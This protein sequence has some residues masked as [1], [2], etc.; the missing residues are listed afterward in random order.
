METIEKSKRGSGTSRTFGQRGVVLNP[1]SH[2]N[3]LAASSTEQLAATLAAAAQSTS[4]G[5]HIVSMAQSGGDDSGSRNLRSQEDGSVGGAAGATAGSSQD[6]MQQTNTT[7]QMLPAR[8]RRMTGS[9]LAN[10]G[11]NATNSSPSKGTMPSATVAF[12]PQQHSAEHHSP[13]TSPRQQESLRELSQ[14][15]QLLQENINDAN[16]A[17][18]METTA[19]TIRK[20]KERTAVAAAA[21]YRLPKT[22]RFDDSLPSTADA[23]KPT[24]RHHLDQR[25]LRTSAS[26]TTAALAAAVAAAASESTDAPHM[27]AV[28]VS[29]GATSSSIFASKDN[30]LLQPQ[31]EGKIGGKVASF[32]DEKRQQHQRRT[33][34]SFASADANGTTTVESNGRISVGSS[35][36]ASIGG[37]KLT[38][39]T[40][41]SN[42]AKAGATDK[43]KI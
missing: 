41:Y 37:S 19:Q 39:G 22:L 1:D 4:H 2:T 8:Q 5:N 21:G 15:Q 36:L 33:R 12:Q 13:Q 20:I 34:N 17:M 35:T 7:A 18:N 32:L 10:A 27:T 16:I 38:L 23:S 24:P 25:E 40:R 26:A 29:A 31:Q 28:A 11:V 3:R 42:S 30:H 43:M 9:R 6:S 14:R